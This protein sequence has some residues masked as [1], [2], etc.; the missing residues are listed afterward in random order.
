[1]VVY[2]I[3]DCGFFWKVVLVVL[4][5]LVMICF[6]VVVFVGIGMDFCFGLSCICLKCVVLFGLRCWGF[7]LI[8]IC[9]ELFC[10][11]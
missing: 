10:F 8:G 3:V 11:F 2:D 7:M 6:V 1:M 9:G 4:G 5:C